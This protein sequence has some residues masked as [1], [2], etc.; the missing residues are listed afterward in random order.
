MSEEGS[1]KINPELK[2]WIDNVLVPVMVREYLE[3]V[4]QED[5]GSPVLSGNPEGRNREGVQ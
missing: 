3:I 2:A 4:R 1:I 5:N